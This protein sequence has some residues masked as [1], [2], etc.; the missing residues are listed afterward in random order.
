MSNN[1]H[2]GEFVFR[3]SYYFKILFIDSQYIL[4]TEFNFDQ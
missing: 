3:I 2:D 1:K 4:K